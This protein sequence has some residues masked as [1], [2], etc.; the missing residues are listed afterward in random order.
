[1]GFLVELVS[2][3]GVGFPTLSYL[4]KE[5]EPLSGSIVVYKDRND[6]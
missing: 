1:M 5:T 2:E 6:A 3:F 4:M